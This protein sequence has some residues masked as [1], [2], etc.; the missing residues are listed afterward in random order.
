MVEPKKT[1]K[2][3][4]S[5]VHIAHLIKDFQKKEALKALT[6]GPTQLT[7]SR[8]VNQMQYHTSGGYQM[9]RTNGSNDQQTYPT[10]PALRLVSEFI[11][12]FLWSWLWCRNWSWVPDTYCFAYRGL[13]SC[14]WVE[15]VVVQIREVGRVWRVWNNFKCRTSSC[16]A[17]RPC[18]RLLSMVVL[19]MKQHYR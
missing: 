14:L 1:R 4:S 2:R 11:N 16:I 17:I 15:E 5:H 6:L 19:W 8:G 13:I 18:I 3:C 12:M 7:L 9:R 10:F